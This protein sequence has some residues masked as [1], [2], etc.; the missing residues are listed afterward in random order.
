MAGNVV[1][2]Y[3]TETI[4]KDNTIYLLGDFM[5][6]Y[7]MALDAGTTSNRCILF[8][9]KGQMCS[10][11]QKEFTQYFPKPGWVEHN[12]DEIW[13]TMHGVA[14][15]AMNKIK[16]ICYIGTIFNTEEELRGVRAGIVKDFHQK[17][18]DAFNNQKPE[19]Y[20]KLQAVMSATVATIDDILF[21][22]GCEV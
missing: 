16:E 19:L 1:A 8:N 17:K 18:E 4:Y 7:V 21:R 2:N 6:K 3:N 13:S 5:S 22:M 9:E 15:E 12:A 14:V 10:V 20:W 11:S